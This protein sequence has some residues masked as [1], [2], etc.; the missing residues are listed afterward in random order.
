MLTQSE[1]MMQTA[2]LLL[3]ALAAF[4]YAL[5]QSIVTGTTV[6][7]PQPTGEPTFTIVIPCFPGE[8]ACSPRTVTIEGRDTPEPTF[9]FG[10]PSESVAFGAGVTQTALIL[11][12]QSLVTG[13]TISVPVPQETFTFVI[14][15]YPGEK[16]CSPRTVTLEARDPE[17]QTLGS[18]SRSASIPPTLPTTTSSK[19]HHHWEARQ[20][21][22]GEPSRSV[23]IWPYSTITIVTTVTVTA[24]APPSSS[25]SP[26]LTTIKSNVLSSPTTPVDLTPPI[27]TAS[28]TGSSISRS[29]NTDEGSSSTYSINTA[30]ASG[31]LSARQ[32]LGSPTRS[33]LEWPYPTIT[34]TITKTITSVYVPPP[35]SPPSSESGTSTVPVLTVPVKKERQVLG[36]PTRSVSW[37]KY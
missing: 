18:V 22:V 30:D 33:V 23:P 34:I 14:P 21:L 20:T 10:V 29:I 5:P 4:C 8:T 6:S 19:S 12:R 35:T 3:P 2:L 13:T 1:L 25:S 32:V 11:P 17:P 31:V 26:P 15:C 36:K 28:S 24:T 37:Y 16:S 9:G 27:T 7:A